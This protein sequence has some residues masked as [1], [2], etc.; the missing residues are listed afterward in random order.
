VREEFG[1]VVGLLMFEDAEDGAEEFA[2]DGD[3]GLHF[4]F[5][6]GEQV[7]AE[8]VFNSAARDLGEPQMTDRTG[9]RRHSLG[10]G[11][12]QPFGHAE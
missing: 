6:A 9:G 7:L 11:C 4:G 1:A 10:E 5:A 8:L 3:Q 2:H 12:A